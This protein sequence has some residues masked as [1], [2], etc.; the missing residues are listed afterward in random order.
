MTTRHILFLR[1]AALIAPACAA[2]SGCLSST[3]VWDSHFGQAVRTVTQAQIID[4]DAATH[5]PSVDG[6]DGKAA[7]A[8]MSNYNKSI[9]QAPQNSNAFVIGVGS[10][11]NSG[12]GMLTAPSSGQ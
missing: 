3:P 4:P 2:L 6:L 12:G 8:A 11:G 5:N 1:R 9:Q 10:N 7:V